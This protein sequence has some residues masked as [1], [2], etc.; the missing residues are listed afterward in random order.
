MGRL[1]LDRCA[2]HKV[3]PARSRHMNFQPLRSQVAVPLLAW[4]IVPIAWLV[5][6]PY[7]GVRHDAVLYTAQALHQMWPG[8]FS[9]DVFFA[10]GSQDNYS[11]FS[12][13]MAWLFDHVGVAAAEAYIP[14]A[15]HALLLLAAGWL[16]KSAKELS[17]FEVW[18]GLL[19]LAAFPHLYDGN[20]IFAFAEPFLTAR[21][22]AEPLCVLAVVLLMSRR[23]LAAAITFMLAAVVHPLI[24]LP[25]LLVGWTCL[26]FVDRRWMWAACLL[27]VPVVLGL[28]GMA[29]FDQLLAQYDPAWW[30]EVLDRNPHVLLGHW[31]VIGWQ[32]VLFD[33]GVLALASTMVVGQLQII[34]R[35][36]ILSTVVLMAFSY[37]GADLIH[38]VLI[39]SL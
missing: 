39:T 1:F 30:A 4:L 28:G 23:L 11:V 12:K 17:D 5:A 19:A 2:Q 13:V 14:L 21:T 36:T 35:A 34:C 38:N 33:L 6:R 26:C 29:P 16:L 15:F 32:T 27:P 10:H 18:M 37:V 25:V 3:V 22:I 9:Q 24:S 31:P 8:I 7:L 20:S